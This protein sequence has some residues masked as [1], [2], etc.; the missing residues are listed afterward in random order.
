MA[1]SPD[2]SGKLGCGY[3]PFV[4]FVEDGEELLVVDEFFLG[5]GLQR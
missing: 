4:F 3:G 5:E 2:E 1:E